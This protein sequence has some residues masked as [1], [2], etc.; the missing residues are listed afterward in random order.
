MKPMNIY[1]AGVGG[2][3]IGLL[4]D[5][6][7]RACVLAGYNVRG[8]DT[9]GLAQRGGVVVSHLRIGK[10]LF[11]PR[12]PPRLADLVVGLERLEALRATRAMLKPG[13][14]VVY[15][16]TTY[17]PIAVRTKEFEYPSTDELVSAV[18]GLNGKLEQVQISELPD[19]RMQNVALIGRIASLKAIEDVTTGIFEQALVNALPPKVKE[20]N[21]AVF[22]E[23]AQ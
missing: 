1:M 3:G 23:A 13:G 18:Q 17:Q 5:V 2:Q 4:S 10:E 15:Y 12:V 6:L 16:E 8:C 22:K 20:A 9:H 11:G 7:T 14:T 21:M 19:P